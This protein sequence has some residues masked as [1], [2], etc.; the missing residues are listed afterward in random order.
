[1]LFLW[2]LL[3]L[4]PWV[5]PGHPSRFHFTVRP[6]LFPT[7]NLSLMSVLFVL[8]GSLAIPST[9]PPQ[10]FSLCMV[11]HVCDNPAGPQAHSGRT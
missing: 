7:L 10:H 11:L 2:M 8:P 4:L 9:F 1:M 5:V 3:S 6:P